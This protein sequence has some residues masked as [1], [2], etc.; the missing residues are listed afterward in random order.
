MPWNQRSFF[1]SF[2]LLMQAIPALSQDTTATVNGTVTDSTGGVVADARVTVVNH[3]T[4]VVAWNG[5]TNSSGYYVALDI[6]VGAYDI[7]AEHSGF[8]KT[9]V[10]YAALSV[11]Q[12]AEVNLQMNPG[13]VTESITVTA[14]SATTQLETS[15]SSISTLISPSEVDDLPLPSRDPMQLMLLVNGVSSGGSATGINTSQMSI[16]GSRSLNT[17]VLVDGVSVLSNSTGQISPLPSQD[18]MQ[19]FRVSTSAYSAESGRTSGGTISMV[20]KSG[21]N[22]FHGGLYELFRNEDLNANNFFNNNRSIARPPDRYNQFGGTIGGP[23]WIPKLYNG[24]NRTFFF[25]N[26]D[27]TVQRVSSI[28]TNTVP[29]TAFKQGDF[30][31]AAILVYDPL[32]ST[33]FPKN[34]IPANRINSAAAKVMSFL[35]DPNSPGTPDPLNSRYINNNINP[36]V[37]SNTS[38]KYTGRMDE[39]LGARDRLFGTITS[40][41]ANAPNALTFSNV[42]NAKEQGWTN[43]Y[44][45]SAGFTHV[46]SPTFISELRYGFD[47]YIQIA[48]FPSEGTNVQQVLGIG[49]SPAPLPPNLVVT[50]WAAMGPNIGAVR[51]TY[52]NAFMLNA[53]ATKVWRAQTVKFGFQV[54]KNQMNTFSP[55]GAFMGQYNFGGGITNK[56][57]VGGN[58]VDTLADFLLGDITSASYEIPQPLTGRR[59]YNLGAFLQDDW[60][61]NSR[62]TVNAGVRWDYE[63]PMSVATNIYSRF[64]PTNGQ[65]LVAGQNATDTLN[66]TTSKHNFQ[67]RVGFAYS[68]DPKTVVR[69]AFGIFY[70]Q[71]M[72]NL[73]SSITYP[74]YDITVSFPQPSSGVPQPFSLSQGMPLTG[75]Q[76]LN[77]PS[78]ILKSATVASPIGGGTSFSQVNPLPAM[79]QW[80]YGLQRDLGKGIMVEANYVGNHGEH[81]PMFISAN[82]VPFSAGPA[83]ALANSSTVTQSARPFPLISSISGLYDCGD[84]SYNSLQLKAQR[85]VSSDLAF[86]VAYTWSKAIDDAS[87][88]FSSGLPNGLTNGQFPLYDRALDHSLSAFDVPQSLAI[89][90]QYRTHGSKWLR[91]FQISPIF[92]AQSGK[93]L[94]ITQTNEYPGVSTQRPMVTGANGDTQLANSIP[95]GTGVQYLM[96]PTDPNF[97][98]SPSGPVY[99]GSGASRTQI[100]S[101][102]IGNLGRN[103][104]RSSGSVNLNL[105]VARTFQLTERIKLQFRVDA[106]NA[107]NHTN[108]SAPATALTVATSNGR[109]IF[110][111]PGFGLITSAASARFLQIVTRFN[112]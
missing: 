22:L 38:P 58:A 48:A 102:A 54:R 108:F 109:A 5:A 19:E 27:Q 111:S 10:D 67:P 96:L 2:V 15:N 26:L 13:E 55:A 66:V 73:G 80:N 18:A 1:L 85:R 3:N 89:A 76:N 104:Q 34:V 49:T 91:G 12:R 41:A 75:V 11:G 32:S 105:S 24:R 77:N 101:A 59:N 61:V 106:F 6:P 82:Q 50:N 30:S 90:I 17:E 94:T 31:S 53:S 4:G 68:L 40:W 42:L 84:S 69:S 100:V 35:P 103:T 78:D 33:P 37:L 36:Q 71:V 60:K 39:S 110:N 65:L 62:L 79:L 46:I 92:V 52:S 83:L 93:P 81:L 44:E 70:A 74:G 16:N 29:T 51:I 86:Q 7:T 28:P 45:A 14:E 63:A 9:K 87:G 47:R 99:T 43:G 72:S 64:D 112:F 8:K 21:T 25:F 56:G 98:L 57:G 23:V 20:V 95:N 97:P 88:I 107:A